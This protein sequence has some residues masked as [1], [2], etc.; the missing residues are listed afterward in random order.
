[1]YFVALHRSLSKFDVGFL[2]RLLMK[3]F[4][5]NVVTKW[6]ITT[7]ESRFRISKATFPN[8]SMKD[9][10]VSF[11]SCCKLTKE[12]NTMWCWLVANWSPNLMGSKQFMDLVGVQWTNSKLFLW[13]MWGTPCITRHHPRCKV[14]L[15]RHKYQC[16]HSGRWCCH[17][18]PR[19]LLSKW[20]AMEYP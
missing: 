4:G 13:V 10:N 9:R 1:M 20:E 7:I 14:P 16:I 11:F 19:L 3:S 12:T 8:L 15:E 17:I 18:Y 5:C 2:Q 6:C